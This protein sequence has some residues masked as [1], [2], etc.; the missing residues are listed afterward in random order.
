MGS[1]NEHSHPYILHLLTCSL[2]QAF[3]QCFGTMVP[4]TR[5]R[6]T[7]SLHP[8]VQHI[9]SCW[10]LAD[11]PDTERGKYWSKLHADESLDYFDDLTKL[12]QYIKKPGL[13]TNTYTDDDDNEQTLPEDDI[14]RALGV[15]SYI[16]YLQNDHGPETKIH[17]EYDPLII[18]DYGRADFEDYLV[19][20]FDPDHPE[21]VDRI[22]RREAW[23]LNHPEWGM[24]TAPSTSDTKSPQ[25]P[26]RNQHLKKTITDFPQFT[27]DDKFVLWDEE[28]RAVAIA[29]GVLWCL[30]PALRPEED[31]SAMVTFTTDNKFLFA[32]L[33]IKVK[34]L[35]GKSIIRKCKEGDGQSAYLTIKK[36]Y[37]QSQ[38][39]RNKLKLLKDSITFERMPPNSAG[40]YHHY[41]RKYEE[42]I[43]EYNLLAK[44]DEQYDD[45]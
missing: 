7:W 20:H 33:K 37:E 16:T 22:G 42:L 23:K 32:V 25:S 9:L 34:T 11:D 18:T 6:T 41:L 10:L 3:L 36:T 24:T 45:G 14:H 13:R 29:Q 38:L 44:P 27:D 19:V 2:I 8:V 21:K 40:K 12:R 26:Q 28:L 30:D 39:G 43:T 4:I 35:T 1:V 5:Q 15:D 17:M 31:S